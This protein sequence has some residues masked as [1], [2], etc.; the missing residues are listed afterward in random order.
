VL[1]V[2]GVEEKAE[3]EVAIMA[4]AATVFMVS[5]II[6]FADARLPTRRETGKSVFR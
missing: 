5:S 4:R 2:R 6:M 3:A 1:V